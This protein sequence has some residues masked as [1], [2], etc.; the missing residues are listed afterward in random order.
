MAKQNTPQHETSNPPDQ[1][2]KS[3]DGNDHAAIRRQTWRI[4]VPVI[5]ANSSIPLVGIV[6]T[7]VMGHLDAPHYIGAVAMGSFILSLI[8]ALFGFLRMATTGFVA[9]AAGA[10][11]GA[12]VL[13]HFWRAISVAIIL[14]LLTIMLIPLITFLASLTLTL[15]DAVS[16]GMTTYLAIVCISA[17]A[18]TINMVIL[19]V[20]FGLQRI[21]ATVI[22]L[23]TIN[24]INIIGNFV[25]VYGLDMRVEGVAL[26]TAISHYCGLL[27]TLPMVISAIRNITPFS[28][29]PLHVILNLAAM[30][31][32][33]GLGF[34][35]TIRTGCIILSELIVL[36]AASAIDDVS[37]AASQI[38]FVIF[39]TIA[40]PLDGFA[41]AAEAL[42]GSAIGKRNRAMFN[43]TL[44]ET[45]NLAIVMSMIMAI[46]LA[47]F[48]DA[49][50]NLMTSIPEVVEKSHELLPILVVMP[51]VSVIAFQMDG[52]F[53]GAT[54]GRDMRNAM[55]VSM[56]V[57]LPLMYVMEIWFGLIGIWLA[58]MILLGLR[59]ATLW[60]RLNHIRVTIE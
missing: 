56:I 32:Y 48:G 52:V 35:L 10:N 39:A 54:M 57:F 55:L 38:G 4:A 34:D 14:G 18:I 8:L 30:R 7:A 51:V 11:D 50:I 22:Q 58:F 36:N 37:L 59:G 16:S 27:V 33:L 47:L 9:Q 31:R 20:M 24:T 13:T 28:I 40:Y 45:T 29:L 17:P 21:R 49:F 46:L 15:S 43:H 53:V 3:I 1:V 19:G 23:I 44:R 41:H 5:I 42:T 2:L 12:M 26:A 25:F 60:M 6:D